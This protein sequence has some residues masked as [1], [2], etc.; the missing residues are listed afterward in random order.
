[1]GRPVMNRV[2]LKPGIDLR[3]DGGCVVAPPSVHPS[4]RPYSWV[5]RRTPD[6]VPLASLP[7]W[8]L[9]AAGS[10]RRGHPLAHWRSLVREG[11]EEGQRNESLASLTGHLLGRD[12]DPEVALE[13]LLAWNRVRCR[14][15]LEDAEV[16][17][18]VRSIW[19][20]HEQE[21]G[22]PRSQP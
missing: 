8:L 4:G 5:K 11:V 12:V 21:Q 22:E 9:A 3:G 2:G 14:P 17:G 6:E 1:P 16:A 15:P 7:D 10:V 18:V 13:L 20:L 19:R